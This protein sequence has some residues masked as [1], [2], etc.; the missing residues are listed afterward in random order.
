MN[1]IEHP[2]SLDI[3]YFFLFVFLEPREEEIYKYTYLERKVSHLR[4]QT[5]R[6]GNEW[7]TLIIW[8]IAFHSPFVSFII[9]LKMCLWY[10][11]RLSLCV[12]L[13]FISATN[14]FPTCTNSKFIQAIFSE[15]RISWRICANLLAYYSHYRAF[16]K[17][18]R[19]ISV[20]FTSE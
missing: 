16:E 9:A 4:N 20:R 13:E 11:T 2:I 10:L 14:Y 3:T 7:L 8:T 12:S 1:L 5:W 18:K 15:C 19:I 6:K 17:S